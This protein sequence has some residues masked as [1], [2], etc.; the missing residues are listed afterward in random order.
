[1]SLLTRGLGEPG[2]L[3]TRGLG[4]PGL[5]TPTPGGVVIDEAEAL[6]VD[7]GIVEDLVTEIEEALAPVVDLGLLEELV[8]ITVIE[9][10]TVTIFPTARLSTHI[11]LQERLLALQIDETAVVDV[12]PSETATV[13]LEASSA[14]STDLT[15]SDTPTASLDDDDDVSGA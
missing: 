14:A 8:E 2:L 5:R 1:M 11:D 12:S 15:V 7:I 6:L 3:V 13:D 10:E 4:A 9:A